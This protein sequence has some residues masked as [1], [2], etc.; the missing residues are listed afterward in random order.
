MDHK[1]PIVANIDY[2]SHGCGLTINHSYAVLSSFELKDE[3]GNEVHK[4][5]MMRNMRNFDPR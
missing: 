5:V 3:D 1:N 2:T 4:M